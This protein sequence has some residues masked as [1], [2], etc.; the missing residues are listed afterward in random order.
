MKHRILILSFLFCTS[1][2]PLKSINQFQAC[3][4][5]FTPFIDTVVKLNKKY[6]II[7]RKEIRV[8]DTFYTFPR[9]QKKGSQIVELKITIQ[10][11]KLSDIKLL[12]SPN[13][14]YLFACYNVEESYVYVTLNDSIFHEVHE[15][16]IVSTKTGDV[17]KDGLS[18]DECSGQWN[19][20]NKWVDG[21]GDYTILIDP[22][23]LKNK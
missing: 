12:L 21:Y 13:G 6:S 5:K 20:K 9:I 10:S 18:N 2:F 23:K 7:L 22:K 1:I 15:C 8:L 11:S 19:S 17:I 14:K 3:E 16:S 4:Y